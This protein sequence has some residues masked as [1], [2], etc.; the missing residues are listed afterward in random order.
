[1]KILWKLNTQPKYSRFVY[2]NAITFKTL[3][4][5]KRNQI[6]FQSILSKISL[7]FNSLQFFFTSVSVVEIQIPY[8][9]HVFVKSVNLQISHALQSRT[10]P[11]PH[12]KQLYK[13]FIQLTRK[14]FRGNLLSEKVEEFIS[15]NFQVSECYCEVLY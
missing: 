13:F 10:P 11:I 3:K 7:N 1:M 4:P 2:L 6:F 14:T 12:F 8:H 15:A 9:R 5:L